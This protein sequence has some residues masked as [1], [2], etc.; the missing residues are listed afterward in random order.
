MSSGCFDLL[1]QLLLQGT[2]C[3]VFG[4]RGVSRLHAREIDRF[5]FWIGPRTRGKRNIGKGGIRIH[6]K[7]C[8]CNETCRD[9]SIHTT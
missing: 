4:S 8:I 6:L 1:S 5:A 2:S 3:G 7:R 9:V